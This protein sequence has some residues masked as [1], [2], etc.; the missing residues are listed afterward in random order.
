VESSRWDGSSPGVGYLLREAGLALV[1]LVMEARE[2]LQE[3]ME[4]PI[5]E[6]RM[7]AV[8]IDGT[9]F[10][11][12]QMIVVLGISTDGRKTVLGWREGRMR[13]QRSASCSVIWRRA[14]STSACR[15]CTCWTAAKRWLR[16]CAGM[17]AKPR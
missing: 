16:P 10:R 8:L 17:R 12:R 14:G 2:N 3:L 1:N 5:S 7:C 13:T 11:D 4:R 6:L 9:P 15:V